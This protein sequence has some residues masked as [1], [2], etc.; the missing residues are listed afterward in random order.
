MSVVRTTDAAEAAEL[1][2]SGGRLR[3]H[4]HDM[5]ALVPGEATATGWLR[6]ELPSHL[7]LAPVDRPVVEI[8]CASLLAYPAGHVDA[9]QAASEAEAVAVYERLI[10][11][12]TAGPLVHEVSALVLD[13]VTGAVAAALLVTAMPAAA[14]WNGGPWLCDLFVVPAQRGVGLGRHLLEVMFARCAECGYERVGLSVTDGNPAERLY[15]AVGF[16]RCRSV[17][18]IDTGS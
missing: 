13:D 7:L 16:E 4:A 10:D 14:W 5:Q 11:G 17:F 3:R 15:R 8:A 18:V 6:S 1:V 2:A 9:A 12:H